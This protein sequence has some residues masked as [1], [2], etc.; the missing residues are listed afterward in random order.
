MVTD[1]DFHEPSGPRDDHGFTREHEE[2]FAP[3]AR[4][5]AVLREISVAVMHA[6]GSF[7]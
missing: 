2:I 3:M 1:L 7:G 5:F 4:L 6:N